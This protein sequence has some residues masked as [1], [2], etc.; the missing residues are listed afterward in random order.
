MF[1]PAS[2][3]MGI[4]IGMVA[5]GFIMRAIKPMGQPRDQRG[6]FVKRTLI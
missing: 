3:L 5:A 1:D 4:A 6:R 2:V